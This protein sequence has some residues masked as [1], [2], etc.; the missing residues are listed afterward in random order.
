MAPRRYV[1]VLYNINTGG[2]KVVGKRA[3]HDAALKLAKSEYAR[4]KAEDWPLG[5]KT[6]VYVY[7][8][9]GKV[10]DTLSYVPA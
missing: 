1:V 5:I 7:S 10:V 9:T 6:C 2:S 3:K 8:P 4:T